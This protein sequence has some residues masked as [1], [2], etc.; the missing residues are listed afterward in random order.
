MV[1]FTAGCGLA[2]ATAKIADFRYAIE[3]PA[4]MGGGRS[5]AASK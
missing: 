2:L 4:T 1:R 3:A 5:G